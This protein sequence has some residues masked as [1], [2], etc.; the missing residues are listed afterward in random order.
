[1]TNLEFRYWLKGFFV[2]ENN[3]AGLTPRQF[4][5]IDNHLNLVKAVEGQLSDDNKKI[6]NLLA[7]LKES[8]KR[9]LSLLVDTSDKL[10]LLVHSITDKLTFF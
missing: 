8:D 9:T 2:L 4:F 1:M 6:A 5:I 3:S 7:E 10:R